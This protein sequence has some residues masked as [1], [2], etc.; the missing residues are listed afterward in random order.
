MHFPTEVTVTDLGVD[1]SSG[2]LVIISPGGGLEIE[3]DDFDPARAQV[4]VEWSY[5]LGAE[6]REWRYPLDEEGW[7]EGCSY[8]FSDEP[9]VHRL[10]IGEHVRCTIPKKL[11]NAL[12]ALMAGSVQ[13]VP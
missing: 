10:H 13:E 5:R 4:K 1:I 3:I 11:A 12:H 9:E 6:V 8:F 7:L 2:G